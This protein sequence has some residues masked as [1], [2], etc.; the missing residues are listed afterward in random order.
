[1][2]K[3]AQLFVL[4]EVGKVGCQE[5]PSTRYK[6]EIDPWSRPGSSTADAG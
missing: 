4:K 6:Q 5:L 2:K 1:M 3:G